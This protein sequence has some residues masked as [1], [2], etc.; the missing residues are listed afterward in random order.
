LGAISWRRI[1]PR[2]GARRS[3]GACDLRCRRE[4]RSRLPG[5]G[6]ASA[7]AWACR[8]VSATGP[9]LTIRCVTVIHDARPRCRV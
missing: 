9:A 4:A 8:P 1:A 2:R 5:S 6:S 3:R 7:D